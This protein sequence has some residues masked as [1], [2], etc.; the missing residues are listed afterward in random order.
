MMREQMIV[1]INK[2][3]MKSLVRGHYVN[4]DI[5]EPD[6]CFGMD[7]CFEHADMVARINTL[8]MGVTSWVAS[9]YGDQVENHRHCEFYGCDRHLDIG[10]LSDYGV[11]NA[12]GLADAP[13]NPLSVHAYP[14]ELERAA[15]S[16]ADDD[17]RWATW[18]GHARRILRVNTT[19][20]HR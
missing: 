11:D 9:T 5:D 4:V 14:S 10:A 18:C 8:K 6:S 2:I 12:L 16:M 15:R 3:A 13:D 20:A 7:F 19:M 1:A 17:P